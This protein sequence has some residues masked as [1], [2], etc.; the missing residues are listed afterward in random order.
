MGKVKN[1]IKGHCSREDY[2]EL[3]IISNEAIEYS[4][5]LEGYLKPI[6]LMREFKKELD[7]KEVKR[8]ETT[9]SGK[10]FIFI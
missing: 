10:L 7:N 5:S 8:V 3:T 4:G 9:L 6:E 1:V 2:N